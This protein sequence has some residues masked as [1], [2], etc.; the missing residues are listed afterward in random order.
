MLNNKISK[1]VRLAIAFGAASTAAFTSN[2]FAA[3]EGA[4]A[5]ERIEVTGSRIK[6]TDMATDVPIT[7]I[8]R[9]AIE[10][11]GETS[12]ADLLRGTTFNTFGSF[13]PQSGSSAQGVSSVN[14]RGLGSDRT[15]ILVDGRRLPKS[16]LT[17]SSQDLNAIPM[18]AVERVEILSD[19][20]GAIY[21]SDAIGGV[22][23]VILRKDFNGAEVNLGAGQIEH[24]GGDREN[25]SIVF[26]ASSDKASIVAGAGWSG[27]DI[28]Y[29][30]D[31]P[32]Y[33][34]GGSVYSNNFTTIAQDAD[35]NYLP[36]VS[37][38]DFFSPNSTCEGV[39]N[40]NFYR[41]GSRCGFNFAAVSAD[42]ASIKNRS[43]FVNASY[44]INDDWSVYST[45]NISQTKSFG[46]YAP[47]L[48]TS[49]YSAFQID[50]D[51]PNNPTNPNSPL[52]DASLGMEQQPLD[53]W[54]R[55]AAL[56]NR[57]NN[58]TNELK[59]ITFGTKGV[60]NDNIYVEFG[61]RKTINE[62]ANTGDGYVLRAIARQYI[63]D[64][65]YDLSNP[66]GASPA[67]L[68]AMKVTTSRLGKFNQEE[69]YGN[70]SFDVMDLEAG[71]VQAFVGFEYR[72]ED[73]A[74]KYDSLSEAGQVG[75][76]SG[77]S[78]GGDRSVGAIFFEALVPVVDSLELT[79]A[80]RYDDYSDYG[81]DF[82][83]KVS[84][85]Y[86]ATD[87]L[88]VRASWGKG[89][90]A[91]SLPDLTQQPSES[92]DSVSDDATCLAIGEEVG[93]SSQIN[94]IVISNPN[95][96]SEKSD[97]Y[98]LGLIY[99][100]ADNIDF[101]IDYYSTEIT[102]RIRAFG[103]Q[104][105]IDAT[106]RGD[107][108]PPAFT[109]TRA[110]NGGITQ[111]VRGFGNDGSLETTG[112][113]F[114]ARSRFEFSDMG[115]LTTNLQVSHVI[116]Y[117]IDGGRNLTKD[118]GTPKQR[119]TLSNVYS[120]DDIDFTWNLSMVGSQYEDIDADGVG[121]GH[122]PTW[123]THDLQVGYSTPWN[124]RISVG[125]QNAFGKE[126]PLFSYDGRDYNFNL[127]SGYGRVAYIN[128]KQSF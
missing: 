33:S 128:Y 48:D 127:Y 75:G 42:E 37:N 73:Y 83:P 101:E 124:G 34:P 67:V 113:D 30:R 31:F 47:S 71:T 25:G 61:A 16:T 11:S 95:L 85:R 104:A 23:N 121:S 125:A 26:G 2:V 92:A 100:V 81:S 69:V 103:S 55:F 96:E 60:I 86:E 46:R 45:M 12:V 43:A 28:V 99:Q 110:P 112:I 111:V 20:A 122:I 1:A 10:L 76:S 68:N 63:N 123:V 40:E 94:A 6:R 44:E 88:V 117:N 119:V 24:E 84:A 105:I 62:S 66:Y 41:I 64:G 13:R 80:G 57:D 35:G 29:A 82:S 51:S 97:Q 38:F 77:S 74:D 70:V 8:D 107:A 115:S 50:A 98:S 93:C 27:R 91:P 17:G 120:L 58:L 15:L 22:I 53:F 59:D 19:G 32:W 21:G 18:A 78:A 5:V 126:P 90:R 4:E 79:F 72:T 65:T 3:E 49:A 89:F 87:D 54:H 39:G 106:L 36:G 102:N 108:L 118:P 52:Y 109:V 9:A 14:L 114:K 116:D 7:V 56:G